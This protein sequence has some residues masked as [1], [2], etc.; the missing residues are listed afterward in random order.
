M[1]KLSNSVDDYSCIWLALR[2]NTIE[3]LAWDLIG[4][5]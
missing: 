2:G 3:L 1:K 5:I 4:E